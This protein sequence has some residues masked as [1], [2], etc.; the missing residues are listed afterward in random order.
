M[1]PH[2]LKHNLPSRISLKKI[3][4]GNAFIEGLIASDR[5]SRLSDSV[6]AMDNYFDVFLK[7]A[8]N[9]NGKIEIFLKV[10][11]SV[12]MQCQRCLD[13]ISVPID[14]NTVLTVVAH[15]DEARASIKNQEP[16]IIEN[17]ALEIDTLVED[18]ILLALPII[19]MHPLK[20]KNQSCISSLVEK[21]FNYV[22]DE[23]DLID[24]R[25]VLGIDN[26]FAELKNLSI[27]KNK[28]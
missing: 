23:S 26:P 17:D 13:N 18:E 14:L 10:N 2:M 20:E 16:I 28:E 11:G 21:N 24:R 8:R 4:D 22:N 25:S 27:K 5:F 1:P 15:D 7:S 19:A 9:L 6:I 12:L 3:L